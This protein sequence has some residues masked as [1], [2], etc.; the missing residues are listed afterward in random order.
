M[1][2]HYLKSSL[3]H[4]DKVLFLW[5]LF[6][7]QLLLIGLFVIFGATNVS[8]NAIDGSDDSQVVEDEFRFGVGVA[9]T[10]S[11]KVIQ[12]VT[13]AKASKANSKLFRTTS[14]LLTLPSLP[15]FS[16][17]FF[18]CSHDIQ[19]NDTQL[20]FRNG[21]V[22]TVVET[23]DDYGNCEC[24]CHLNYHGRDCSQPES[25]WRAFI[26]A[27][28]SRN[29]ER[30]IDETVRPFRVF[31]LIHSTAL[32]LTTVEIQMMELN[33][34]V[35][36]FILCDKIQTIDGENNGSGKMRNFRY[37]QMSSEHRN[38]FFLKRLKSKT[39]ILQAPDKCTPKWMYQTFRSKLR[40][41]TSDRDVLLFSGVDEIVNRQTIT[42]LKWF[43]DW[44][45]NQPIK[46]RLKRNAFGFYWQHPEQTYLGS[47]ACQLR[48]LDER[49]DGDPLRMLNVSGRG[50]IVGDLNH[51]GGWFCQYCYESPVQ[52]V[53][54]LQAERAL[55]MFNG[56]A[57]AIEGF[58][59]NVDHSIV[60]AS[61]I[62]SLISAGIFID[63]RLNL[64][65]LHRY[66][67]TYYAP[68]TVVSQPWRYESLLSNTYA[69]YDVNDET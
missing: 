53:H 41:L 24:K 2:L 18:K 56:G 15:T 20:C 36:F 65:R 7:F 33:D 35:D 64:M 49:F 42:Y 5:I 61:Y 31:N 39:I 68:K 62:E 25:I 51:S 19:L 60:D 13:K 27:R 23:L 3:R 57:N 14:A 4:C 48:I 21:S 6:S 46:F 66:S 9:G 55:S 38:D 37:H 59:M 34:S 16:E 47:G 50:M 40:H 22:E 29:S 63:G 44:T 69:H 10:Q 26:S 32:S 58:K 54:K 12:F 1:H 17:A 8:E 30:A 28:I 11:A 52:I 67:D 43:N 45:Q